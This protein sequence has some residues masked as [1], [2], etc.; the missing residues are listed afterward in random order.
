MKE[1]TVYAAD[2]SEIMVNWMNDNIAGNHKGLIP[3]IMKES[4]IPL[5]DESVDLVLMITLHHEL[6]DPEAL[7]TESIRILKNEGKIC[8]VDWEKKEMTYGPSIEIRKSAEE[9]SDQLKHSG[10]K[11]IHIDDTLENFS[12]LWAEK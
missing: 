4:V 12:L 1:G 5:D 10:F 9:I 7:L 2:I 11:K 8:I 6:E 3:L